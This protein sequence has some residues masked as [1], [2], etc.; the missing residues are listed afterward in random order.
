MILLTLARVASSQVV[1]SPKPIWNSGTK[2]SGRD[3][4]A[5][6]IDFIRYGNPDFVTSLSNPRR[7]ALY[8]NDG[9]KFARQPFWESQRTTDRDHVDVLDFNGDGWLDL[10]GTHE[11]H[12]TLY[13]NQKGKFNTKPDW[14]TGIIANANQTAYHGFEFND[15]DNDGDMD[16]VAADYGR[17]GNIA[18]YLNEGGKL[19]DK[20]AW[21]VKRSGP[22]HEAVLGDLDLAVG[23]QDQAHI[24]ENLTPRTSQTPKRK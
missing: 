21:S 8:R 3:G 23:C 10:A 6:F 17:G 22:A 16:V 4:F 24:Y 14:E 18:V 5:R 11:S 9:V 12:C 7:W 19:V 20:P 1:F 2:Y 13:F 15:V